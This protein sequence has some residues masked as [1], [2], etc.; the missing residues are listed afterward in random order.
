MDGDW[1]AVELQSLIASSFAAI[2]RPSDDAMVNRASGGDAGVMSALV[3]GKTWDQLTQKDLVSRWSSFSYFEPAAYCYFL[4]ALLLAALGDGET[5]DR[6]LLSSAVI[7]IG[8]NEYEVFHRR[9]SSLANR[10]ARLPDDAYAAV[11]TLLTWIVKQDLSLYTRYC[12][13][14]DLKWGWARLGIDQETI[15]RFYRPLFNYQRPRIEDNEYVD[16]AR[17]AEALAQRIE[18]A[19]AH[20]PRPALVTSA[21]DEESAEIALELGAAPAWQRIHPDFLELHHASLTFLN[22]A[23]FRYFL[24]AYLLVDLT[25]AASNANPVFALTYGL[26]ARYASAREHAMERMAGFSESERRV[27]VSYLEMVLGDGSGFRSEEIQEALDSYWRP[28]LDG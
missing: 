6:D 2:P 9:P 15:E 3:A 14:K 5:T 22:A 11:V 13:V 25:G 27:I 1:T 16:H 12:A 10:I 4:Q 21:T 19:F 26:H 28:S 17:A 24:P 8:A 18:A 23:G 20:T 7:Q